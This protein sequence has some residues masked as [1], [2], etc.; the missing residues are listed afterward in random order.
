[1][2][3]THLRLFIL[4]LAISLA[5]F[6]LAAINP[7]RGGKETMNKKDKEPDKKVTVYDSR[8]NRLHEVDKIAKS[9]PEWKKELSPL[10]Y[11]VT[12]E[13]ATEKPYTGEFVQHQGEGIY[14][15]VGCGTE[16]FLSS[17]KFDSGC[18]WP[19]FSAPIADQ[20]IAYQQDNSLWTES[21]TE[22]LCPRCG[23]HLGHV[24]PDGPQPTG[25]RYCVNSA[26]L[27][28]EPAA[29]VSIPGKSEPA[30][31]ESKK[32]E[33]AA[34]GAGCFWGVEA[35]FRDVPGVV[36]TAVGYMGGSTEFPTY[37]DVCTDKT[38]HA[39]VVQVTFDPS[40]VSYEKLLQV[41]WQNHDPTTLN[42]Q[43]PDVG[44]QYRSAI[45]YHSEEQKLAAISSKV[46]LEMSGRYKRPIVTEITP[47]AVFYRAED[48]HQRYLEKRG[49]ASC[50][51]PSSPGEKDE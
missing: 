32:T 41:F 44:S 8:S 4:S 38:G 36:E 40:N 22:I 27:E 48:Y 34:F 42:R 35:V 23:A 51:L 6:A 26:S 11:Q 15:C 30:K 14:R 21:R 37:P 43:G 1:M 2:R 13:K 10:Q 49:L 24:F 5:L 19:S 33:T 47:A 16:L 3:N 46:K 7:T 9:G 20:N 50:H 28:F 45:F 18:G 29:A 39:E 17:R 25:L 12:R 31:R